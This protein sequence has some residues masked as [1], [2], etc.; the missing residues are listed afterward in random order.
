MYSKFCA[1]A[2][3]SVCR[4]TKGEEYPF[5]I[6]ANRMTNRLKSALLVGQAATQQRAK[7]LAEKYQNCPYVYF[8]ATQDTK[9]YAIYFLPEKQRWWMDTIE[10]K[11]EET[12]GLEKVKITF[13]DDIFHPAT[14]RMRLPEKPMNISPC[15]S[16][17]ENCPYYGQCCGCPSTI[18]YQHAESE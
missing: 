14:M 11:P 4:K 18:F 8:I 1:R 5:S 16:N 15:G 12:I 9:I 13:T 6:A 3:N 17:C 7:V 2:D 10:E